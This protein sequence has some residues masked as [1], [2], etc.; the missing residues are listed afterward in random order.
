MVRTDSF[1]VDCGHDVY[2]GEWVYLAGQVRGQPAYAHQQC[3]VEAVDPER[4]IT[5]QPNPDWMGWTD[6][7]GW[8]RDYA[9]PIDKEQQDETRTT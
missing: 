2:A 4:L 5:L 3:S 1:C 7:A 9:D 6:Y 8:K